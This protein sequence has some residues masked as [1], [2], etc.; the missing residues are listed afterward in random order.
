[1]TQNWLP[2]FDFSYLDT[3][4]LNFLRQF[5]LIGNVNFELQVHPHTFTEE[6]NNLLTTLSYVLP[7]F[8]DNINAIQL[9]YL[10]KLRD[11]YNVNSDMV[12]AMLKMSRIL[13]IR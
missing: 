9:D 6:T 8:K 11:L 12:M 3:S 10:E 7:I 5:S 4:V 2:L 1:V 13:G